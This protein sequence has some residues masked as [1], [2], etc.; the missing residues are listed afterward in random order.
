MDSTKFLGSIA[1]AEDEDS[2]FAI[3]EDID[4]F[5]DTMRKPGPDITY[6]GNKFNTITFHDVELA[7]FPFTSKYDRNISS[8]SLTEREGRKVLIQTINQYSNYTKQYEYRA[9]EIIAFWA[10]IKERRP[11][12]TDRGMGEVPPGRRRFIAF[13]DVTKEREGIIPDVFIRIDFPF[14]STGY[15]TGLSGPKAVEFV[16]K[17]RDADKFLAVDDDSKYEADQLVKGIEVEKE[18]TTNLEQAKIVAKQHLNES[19]DYYREL[20]KMEKKLEDKKE[21]EHKKDK[22]KVSKEPLEAKN[23]MPFKQEAEL[24]EHT[25]LLSGE[26]SDVRDIKTVNL[27]PDEYIKA[28]QKGMKTKIKKSFKHQ[29]M[30][31]KYDDPQFPDK[32]KKYAEEMKKGSQFPLLFIEYKWEETY[33]LKTKKNQYS[34]KMAQEGFHRAHAAKLAGIEFVPVMIV[35]PKDK[36]H[37]NIVKEAMTNSILK[38]IQ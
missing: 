3:L 34:Y 6:E 11:L 38:A 15:V 1:I 33:D 28:V 18:H 17:L 37:F 27:T 23:V 31:D 5:I 35:F 26:K 32:V 12:L 2:I 19:K 25:R 36:S 22:K 7:S 9:N 10:T 29:G 16:S 30:E 20:A 24:I 13:Y 14:A 8:Y 21:E 4:N